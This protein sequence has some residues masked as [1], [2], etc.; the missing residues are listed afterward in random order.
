MSDKIHN[1]KFKSMLLNSNAFDS[2]KYLC[3]SAINLKSLNL[4]NLI[5]EYSKDS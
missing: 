2:D 1:L 3:T 4:T 5:V